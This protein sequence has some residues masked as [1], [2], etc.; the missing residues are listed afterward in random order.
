MAARHVDDAHWV[1]TQRLEGDFPGGVAD[2]DYRFTMSGDLIDE[3]VIVP[4]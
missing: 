2:L 4:R 3:L 1:A